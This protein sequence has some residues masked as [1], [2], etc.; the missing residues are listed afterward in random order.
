MVFFRRPPAVG[1]AAAHQD[2]LPEVPGGR[3]LGAG[4]GAHQVIEP[5]REIPFMDVE[6]AVGEE[7]GDGEPEHAVAQEFEPLIVLIRLGAGAGA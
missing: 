1:L 4:L 6:K 3:D 7:L 2:E 5:A